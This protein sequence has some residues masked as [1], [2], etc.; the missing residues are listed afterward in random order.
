MRIEFTAEGL[1]PKKD[2]ANSMW[3]KTLEVPRIQKLRQAA[4]AKFGSVGPL[5]RNIALEL[6]VHAPEPELARIGDLDTFVTGVCDGLMAAAG[7]RWRGHQWLGPEWAGIQPGEAVGI[8]DDAYVV[9]IIAR[10]VADS[11]GARWYKVILEGD[12]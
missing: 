11:K 12:L 1:P 5:R 8:Q 2:G 9:S 7:D 6:E 4:R 3:G 10:K